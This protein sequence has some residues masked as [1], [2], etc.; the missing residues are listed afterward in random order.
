[1]K[2]FLAIALSL[3]LLLSIFSGCTAPKTETTANPSAKTDS[4]AKEN[5][6]GKKMR[7]DVIICDGFDVVTF[8]PPEITDVYSSE[9]AQLIYDRL[10]RLDKDAK[11]IPM[12]AES[13]TN[14]NDK[15][16]VFKLRK[17]VK[18]H[19]GD[20]MKASDVVFSLLRAKNTPKSKTSFEQIDKVEAID[21]YTVRLTTLIPFAPM[22]LKIAGM[23]A[24]I[25]SEKVITEAEKNGG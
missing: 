1:M 11:I 15:E 13:W 16:Y 5:D 8:D 14:P 12:L 6:K 23:G 24:S 22:L 9:T 7:T 21:D 3:S 10:V 4:T 18:F 20:E 19:N 17:G 2:R 25:L